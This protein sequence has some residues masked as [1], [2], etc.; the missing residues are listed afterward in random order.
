MAIDP[1]VRDHQA[2]LGYLQPDGLV[3]SAAA[4][5]E[6]QVLLDRNALPLQQ[7]FLA[8]VEDAVLRPGEDNEPVKAIRDFGAFATRFLGWP[9]EYLYGPSERPIPD[10]LHVDLKELGETLAPTFAFKDP[11]PKD[12]EKPW[13]LVAQVLPSGTDLDAVTT[14]DAAGW[15]ASATRR[16]ERLLREIR[17]PIGL[18]TN[19]TH[20]RLVYAPHGENAGSLT[21]PV[22]AMTEVAGRPILAAL[23]MLLGKPRLLAGPAESRLPALLARSRDIQSS[24]STALARQVIDAAFELLRG[25]QAAD[26]R[27]SGELLRRVLASNPDQVYEG[28]LT[29]LM[30][31][32]FVLYAEDRGL[33]PSGSLYVQNY[34]VH[35]LFE[36]LRS[37]H[38]RFPDTMDQR[39][40]A[41]A[42]LI[43]LFRAVHGGCEH[44]SM[45]LP[46]RYGYLFDPDRFPFLEGRPDRTT[47]AQRLPFVPDGTLFRVLQK[48]LILDG[49]RLSYRTLDV[50]QIGS[51]YEVMMGFGLGMAAGPSIA[52][53][54]K[55]SH[56]APVPINLEELLAQP[57]ADRVKSL[58]AK[59]DQELTGDAASR[60]KSAKSVD[61]LLVA[62]ERRIAR[63]ATPAPVK[64]GGM[65]LVPSD[66][67]RRSG[68]N[69]TPRSLTEPIVRKTLEPILKQLGENATP[70][71]VLELKVCDPAMGSGAFLVEVCRQ[72]SEVLVKAW[73]HWKAL[74]KIPPDED[75]LLYARRLIA[76]RCLYGVDKNPMA[77]DLAKLSIWLATL[78][79]EQPFTFLDH[80]LRS[81][82]SLVGLTRRQIASF[83]WEPDG[84]VQK[85][86]WSTLIEPRIDAAL[87]SRRQIL[88]AG[89]FLPPETKRAK[90]EEADDKL[91]LVRFIGDL[92]VSAFFA[93]DSAK[94]RKTT[95]ADYLQRLTTYLTERDLCKRPGDAVDKLKTGEK[96]VTPFHW[97]IEFPEVFGRDPA[98]FDAIVGNP[99]FAGKN[100]IING[101]A[102]GYVEW[103][104]V[105]HANSH[106]NADL[107]AH[108]FRRSF[109]LLR[110]AGT[111]GLIAT[112]TIAQGDTRGTGLRWLCMNGGTIFCATRRYKWPGEA[113]VV[114]SIVNVAKGSAKLPYELDG[115]PTWNISAY[116]FHAGGHEDPIR[117]RANAGKSFIGSYI[118]GMGFTFDD[119]DKHGVANPK[120]VMQE[121]I[122]KD[123]RNAECIFPYIGGEEVNESPTHAFHRY[124]INFGEMTENEARRWPDLMKIVEERVKPERVKLNREIR[125]TYWWRYGETA[126]G[127]Y[128]AIA[129][130]DRVLVISYVGQH[131][132]FTFLPTGF[133]YATT[134]AVFAFRSGAALAVL[135]CRVHESWARFF[136]SSLE[137]RLRYT[138]TD[139]FETFPFPQNFESSAVLESLG[140]AYFEFRAALMVR[141]GEGLTQTY[142]RFHDPNDSSPDILELR[143]LHEAMD[144][145]V[146]DAYGWTDLS[147]HCQFL[148]DYEDEEDEEAGT[149]SIRRRRKPW[150]YRWPDNVRDEVLA[151]LLDLNAKRAKEESISGAGKKTSPRKKVSKAA[152][153]SAGLFQ[154]D[155]SHE[156]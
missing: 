50:E 61:E 16:F 115:D 36:R 97:E 104:K 135:Q 39:Y 126:P 139:C 83:T 81:G 106:G 142:N 28:L 99:P 95:Q 47:S 32:V 22:A 27:A 132:A 109:D 44:P 74:P 117:L 123:A 96:G 134:L 3:V 147:T 92:A 103:L 43:S 80:A 35:G 57:P 15:S 33:M 52:I 90:L 13:L 70:E 102:A 156:D 145:A 18:L 7:R 149:S 45:M 60:L 107:V 30:R 89:D 108:F 87:A 64:K 154:K 114:V 94:T 152:L 101:N 146:L 26:E 8:V 73:H 25:L 82:D 20:I 31:L 63:S 93:A 68:S 91:N 78:A 38:E 67:R 19:A 48:L 116:L 6:A 100:T 144:R 124:V 98:G 122:S 84:G 143:Q 23:H 75:E 133:V 69:Y 29:V 54:P 85:Q 14:G 130:L 41:W 105:I 88:D 4:L 86:I 119:T 9:D 153:A 148:L 137:E 46:A 141:N 121:L 112:N 62:L 59:T 72:L 113:A 17:V 34:S 21:F 40:G 76:Q 65:L 66:A 5:V 151:R 111:F 136:G 42:Q 37:D 129:S 120:N 155:A 150:R 127:L 140:Q 1:A 55:K 49:E 77:A 2:W 110:Q 58:K 56:G 131:A 24:V 79:K 11:K 51:V 128:A 138:A 10:Q 12:A 125:A 118:L 71:Q 53:K